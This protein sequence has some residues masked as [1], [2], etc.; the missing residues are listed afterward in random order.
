MK[1]K[2]SCVV[3]EDEPIGR[4]IIESYIKKTS[5]LELKAS[6]ETP[7][8]ALDFLQRNQV[9]LLLTDIEM[10]HLNG[11]ELLKALENK[12]SVILVTAYRDYAIDG[13]EEGVVDYLVKPVSYDRFLKAIE[14]VRK[15]MNKTA[16][17]EQNTK[18]DLDRIFIKADGELVKI[19]LNDIIYIEAL[20]DYVRIHLS[21]KERYVTHS[22]MKAMEDQLPEYF[23]RIQRSFI[24]NTRYIKSF[25]GNR[26]TL[27]I[28]KTLPLSVSRKEKLY[29]LLGLDN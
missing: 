5:F 8:K 6:F 23:F 13:F 10:P 28:D 14:R 29:Q 20:K 19:M 24:I 9:N 18:P 27:S 21:K 17:E 12:P 15:L 26:V 7:I 16:S 22:T 1:D 11:L 4:E 3:L 2:I 25:Y